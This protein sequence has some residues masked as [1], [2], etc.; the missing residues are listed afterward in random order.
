MSEAVVMHFIWKA[1]DGFF[2]LRAHG[3]DLPIGPFPSADGAE[4]EIL[5]FH[6]RG[7]WTV[8]DSGVVP[9]PRRL[10]AP[11]RRLFPGFDIWSP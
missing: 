2:Y 11:H 5:K 9:A 7:G 4:N 1:P 8:D 3:A 6:P 10:Q